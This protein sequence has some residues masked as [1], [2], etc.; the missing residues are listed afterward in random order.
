MD[1][2]DAADILGKPLFV[3]CCHFWGCAFDRLQ[4]GKTQKVIAIV[5]TIALI[6]DVRGSGR[7]M[8]LRILSQPDFYLSGWE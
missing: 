6:T 7:N 8:V 3:P 4:N 1:G 2:N 5:A